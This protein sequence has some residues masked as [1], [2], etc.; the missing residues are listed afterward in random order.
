MLRPAP[1]QWIILNLS[2]RG[3]ACSWF[4][5]IGVSPYTSTG[6]VTS[7]TY[8]VAFPSVCSIPC[9]F[10]DMFCKINR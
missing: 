5:T 3:A 6:N 9:P 7:V 4:Q 1:V 10:A 2:T 8:G